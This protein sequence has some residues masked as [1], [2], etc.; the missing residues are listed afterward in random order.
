MGEK[1]EMG[2]PYK[3]SSREYRLFEAALDIHEPW[4]IKEVRLDYGRRRL[5]IILGFERG[6]EFF[7]AQCG[8]PLKAYDTRVREWRHL[9]FFQFETHIFAPL[10]RTQCPAMRS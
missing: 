4:E 10:P 9:D 5:D 1:K 3:T 8:K 2:S 6:S 7:C